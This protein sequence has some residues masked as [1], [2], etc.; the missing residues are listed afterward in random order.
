MSFAFSE[1]LAHVNYMLREGRLV[2]VDAKDGV[3]RIAHHAKRRAKATNCGGAPV[4]RR[5]A[6]GR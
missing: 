5:S 3:E 6:R 4:R 1:V 2:W